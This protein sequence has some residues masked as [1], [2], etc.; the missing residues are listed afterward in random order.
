[1]PKLG[2]HQW[3]NLAL[4]LLVGFSTSVRA[5]IRGQERE[6]PIEDQVKPSSDIPADTVKVQVV[7]PA[8]N[9]LANSTVLLGT[10]KAQGTR[11]KIAGRTNAQGEAIFTK[12]PTGSAQAY[13]VSVPFMGATYGA[14]PFR[15]EGEQ[16]VLVRIVRHPVTTDKRW[17]AQAVSQI[18]IEFRDDRLHVIQQGQV[19]NVGQSTYVF[20]KQG[21][22]IRLPQNAKA[23]QTAAVMSD[24]RISQQGQDIRIRGSMPPGQVMLAWAYDLP[25]ESPRMEFGLALGFNSYRVRVGAE[26]PKGLR[27]AVDG[28]PKAQLFED[29]KQRVLLTELKATEVPLERL[30]I[31]LEGIPGAG[32]L[33]WIAVLLALCAA[34]AGI[35]YA[36]RSRGNPKLAQDPSESRD[37]LLLYLL[38][39]DN[40]RAREEI[41]PRYYDQQKRELLDA[42]ALELRAQESQGPV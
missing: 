16:G 37:Q 5:E 38:E 21:L 33:R 31:K 32:P 29:G 34:V 23:F 17:I 41:G 13:R 18:V 15:L 30:N 42:L 8:G 6:A 36:L 2:L 39:L 40:L 9:V 11:E 4:V 26:A 35:I 27:L 12:L 19:V 25:L 24:Q 1:M 3:L 28:F 7:S 10:L 22:A 14:P 20:P